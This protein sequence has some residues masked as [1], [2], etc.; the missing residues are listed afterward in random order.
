MINQT[1]TILDIGS[2]GGFPGIPLAIMRSDWHFTLVESVAKKAAFLR[3]LIKEL[4]LKN[5]E[6]IN[7]RVENLNHE[8]KF[9]EKYNIVT[10]R[11]VTNLTKL[12]KY[13]YPLLKPKGFLAAYKSKDIDLELKEATKIIDKNKLEL[14]IFSKKLIGVER[15]LITLSSLS[16]F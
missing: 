8:S 15:K 1:P 16:I 14:K 4:E 10:A 11:A 2:G 7:E 3:T 9:K 12:I 6:V 5:V 13:A